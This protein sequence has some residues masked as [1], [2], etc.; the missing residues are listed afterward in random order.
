MLESRVTRFFWVFGL[1]ACRGRA[2]T[3]NIYG[4]AKGAMAG[5]FA[6]KMVMPTVNGRGGE[7]TG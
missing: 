3:E 5:T 7:E 1:R 4:M 2:A 6:E